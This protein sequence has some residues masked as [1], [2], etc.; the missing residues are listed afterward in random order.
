MPQDF[1]FVQFVPKQ[2]FLDRKAV[3]DA[4]GKGNVVALA[5]AGGYIRTLARRSMRPG[6]KKNATAPPGTPP[7]YHA[8]NLRDLIFFA[9]FGSGVRIGPVKFRKG[10][11][12]ALLEFGGTATRTDNRTGKRYTARYRGN[13]FMQPALNQAVSQGKVS[14]AWRGVVR[15]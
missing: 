4:V 5:R 11:A 7:R 13:P 8:K 14:E 3:I 15:R 9:L 2:F 1:G 6:G 12:P 10:E